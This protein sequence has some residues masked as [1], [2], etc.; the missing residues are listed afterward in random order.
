MT[1]DGQRYVLTPLATSLLD[2]SDIALRYVEHTF[3]ARPVFNAAILDREFTVVM[4]D[5]AL[6]VLGGPLL[7]LLEQRAS[8]CQAAD[9]PDRPAAVDDAAR[10]CATVDLMVLPRGFLQDLP[11]ADLYRDRWVCVTAAD[12][13]SVGDMITPQ[14]SPPACAGSSASTARPSSPP[15]ITT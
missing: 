10:R 3:A 2:Q 5:Y 8:E 11:S 7:G 1:R 6:T 15:P 12:N 14:R 4:S 9:R 13:T